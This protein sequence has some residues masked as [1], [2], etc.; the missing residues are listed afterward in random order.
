MSD[1]AAT[2]GGDDRLLGSLAVREG[3]VSAQQV[4]E[5]VSL[6]KQAPA[7]RKL[8]EIL[9]DKGYITPKRLAASQPKSATEP[10]GHAFAAD[11]STASKP[12]HPQRTEDAIM[13]GIVARPV[14]SRS[15]RRGV[16]AAPV[17]YFFAPVALSLSTPGSLTAI[18]ASPGL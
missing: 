1:P 8:G 18:P 2:R 7:A 6:Q 13:A 3:F 15:K 4:E 10:R 14:P 5:C 9:I 12:K 11:E 16:A 17:V